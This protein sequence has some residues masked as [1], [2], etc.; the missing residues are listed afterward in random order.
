[1]V[2]KGHRNLQTIKGISFLGPSDEYV[3]SG[4]DDGHVYIWSKQDGKLQQWLKGD[5]SVINCLEPHPHLPCTMATS[6]IDHDVKIWT[7][8]RAEPLLPGA[9]AESQMEEN[10]ERQGRM[11]PEL[12]GTHI[13][14][15]PD[16]LSR[17]LQARVQRA[18]RMAALRNDGDAETDIEEEQ[19]QDCTIS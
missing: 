2:F 13:L 11:R 6:G 10:E 3:V 17:L 15:T 1:M 12:D 9:Q 8:T 19:P 16:M 5:D 18:A 4:S 14:L 7:P